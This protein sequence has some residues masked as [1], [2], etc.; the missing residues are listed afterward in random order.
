MREKKTIFRFVALTALVFA[1]FLIVYHSPLKV[2]RDK[3]W[4][5]H[6]SDIV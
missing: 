2:A 3:A 5:M 4:Q 6:A 1:K